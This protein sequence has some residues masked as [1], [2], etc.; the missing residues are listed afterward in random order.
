[1]QMEEAAGD[2]PAAA[3]P[4]SSCDEETDMMAISNTGVRSALTV[5]LGVLASG[6]QDQA[7]SAADE[8]PPTSTIVS[9]SRRE[10]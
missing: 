2:D 10:S 3:M 5:A 8:D 9:S 1:M 6:N 4:A 7:A